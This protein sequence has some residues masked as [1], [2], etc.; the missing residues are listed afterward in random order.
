[1]YLNGKKEGLQKSY[2]KNGNKKAVFFCSQGFKD[3]SFQGY[4][5]NKEGALQ[6]KCFYKDNFLHGDFFGYYES[7]NLMNQSHYI[8]DTISGKYYEFFDSTQNLVSN[9]GYYVKGIREGKWIWY[10][11]NEKIYIMGDFVNDKKNGVWQVFYSDGRIKQKGVYTAGKEE[12]LWEFFNIDGSYSFKG[13][14]SDGL[15]NGQWTSYY[16][17]GKIKVI[18]KF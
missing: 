1:M 18:Q 11:Y 15:K 10:H 5:K 8:N 12:G 6:K 9:F 4:Y 13:N 14:Y 2:F 17:N 7:G 16:P 3:G